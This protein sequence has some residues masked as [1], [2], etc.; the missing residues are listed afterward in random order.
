MWKKVFVRKCSFFTGWPIVRVACLTE[1]RAYICTR[2]FEPEQP[3][4]FPE[5]LLAGSVV[6]GVY[7]MARLLNVIRRNMRTP[8]LGKSPG[9]P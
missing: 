7:N 8:F 6:P 3:A 4:I 9:L 2:M 1:T 5:I